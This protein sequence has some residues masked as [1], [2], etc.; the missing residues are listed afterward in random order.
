MK[1]RYSPTSPFVRKVMAVAIELGL[2]DQI[3]KIPTNVWSGGDGVEKDNPLGK[4]PVLI[5]DGGEA[6]YDSPVICEFLNSLS[7]HKNLIPAAGDKR[8]IALRQQA[9]A[10]G[11]LD[12]AILR[13]LEGRRQKGEQSP[14]WVERQK[15]AM[16]RGLDAMEAEAD[17]K[18][19]NDEVT[20][21][22]MAV[23]AAL[24]WLDFRFPDEAWRKQRPALA[25]WYETFSQRP[26]MTKTEPKALP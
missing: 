9:L 15:T 26:S 12:A 14:S 11:V 24:G 5:T 23:C 13:L 20:I 22:Q 3:E 25:E 4:V 18:M 2:E 10:D 7:K 8:W 1:L 21:G 17:C 16:N 6:V 19:L